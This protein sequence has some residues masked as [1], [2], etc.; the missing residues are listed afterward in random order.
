MIQLFKMFY[1][2]IYI[3]LELY[4]LIPVSVAS[5]ERSFTVLRLIKSYLKNRTGNERLS[6]L[7]VISIHKKIAQQLGME[8]IVD[9]FA[10]KKTS[11]NIYRQ[12]QLAIFSFSSIV[13]LF[14]QFFIV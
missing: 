8:M 1:P 11:N 9:E 3:L 5:A 6:S 4:A 10:K 12:L 14:H 2:N 13:M 7:A